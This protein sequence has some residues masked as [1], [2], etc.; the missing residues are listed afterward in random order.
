[1]AERKKSL[2]RRRAERV[3]WAKTTTSQAAEQLG[4][5]VVAASFWRIKLAPETRQKAEIDWSQVDWAYKDD[6]Q[7][8]RET[9]RSRQR[10]NKMRQKFDSNWK[11]TRGANGARIRNK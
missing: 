11:P 8:A 10:V 1:M 4:I 9:G 6:S 7:I 5:S 2:I 3:D